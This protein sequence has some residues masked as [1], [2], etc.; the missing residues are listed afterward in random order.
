M[1]KFSERVGLVSNAEIIQR[2]S[3]N[4]ELRNSLWNVIYLYFITNGGDYRSAY[5]D[6]Q[7]N[8]FSFHTTLIFKATD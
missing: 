4:N 8:D 1:R 7:Y 6:K 3:M 5:K 2:S